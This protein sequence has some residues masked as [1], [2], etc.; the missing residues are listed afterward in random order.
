[1]K[2][3]DLYDVMSDR[4]YDVNIFSKD[5]VEYIETVMIDE[6]AHSWDAKKKLQELF[7]KNAEVEFVR[8]NKTTNR[9]EITVLID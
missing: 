8:A 9:L 5:D 4:V 1:M 6:W 2:L 3:K 7:E